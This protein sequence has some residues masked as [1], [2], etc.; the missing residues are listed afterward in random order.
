MGPSEQSGGPIS[1]HP[2][3]FVIAGAAVSQAPSP[4]W[5]RVNSQEL[6]AKARAIYF[7]YLSE[8]SR[9]TEPSGVVLCGQSGEG[10]VVFE[11]PTLLPDEEFLSTQLL[12]GK[13]S[14]RGLNRG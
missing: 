12:R 11:M 7:R 14:R 6:I 3:S 9:S 13:S 10:R 4:R 8:A 2:P 5:D 1:I